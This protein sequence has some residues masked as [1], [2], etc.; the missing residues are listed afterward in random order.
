[1]RNSTALAT[2]ALL[3][4]ACSATPRAEWVS[5]ADSWNADGKVSHFVDVSS[6]RIDGAIRNA[7]IR[8][9]FP[10]PIR[11][12]AIG[13]HYKILFLMTRFDFNCREEKYRDVAQTQYLDVRL[14]RRAPSSEYPGPWAEVH[15]DTFQHRE[16]EFVCAWAP[17]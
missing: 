2:T 3:V 8:D 11:V 9:V 5:V 16:M 12:H 4:L 1:M 7:W 13:A 10:K 6:I 17:K 14:Y 15:S